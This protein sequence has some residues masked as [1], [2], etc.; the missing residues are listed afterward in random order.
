[1]HGAPARASVADGGGLFGCRDRIRWR[2][3]FLPLWQF[4]RRS[5][6]SGTR[7]LTARANYSH[8]DGGSGG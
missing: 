7:A 1:M 4:R 2:G 6:A 5:L 8:A 3:Q